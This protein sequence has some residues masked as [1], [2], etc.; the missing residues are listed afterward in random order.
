M[1]EQALT[2]SNREIVHAVTPKKINRIPLRKL[3]E[4]EERGG[5]KFSPEAKKIRRALQSVN[6]PSYCLKEGVGSLKCVDETLRHQ[7]RNRL[8]W[9]LDELIRQ[10]NWA[11]ACGVLSVLLQGTIRDKSLTRNRAKYSVA[12]ELLNNIKGG[13]MSP[14]DIQDVYDLWIA[15]LG[16]L[17]NWST[18]DRFAVRLEHILTFLQNGILDEARKA[19]HTLKQVRDVNI[20]PVANLVFG[21]GFCQQWY[22]GLREE[23]QLTELD[24]SGTNMPSVVPADGIHQPVDYSNEENDANSTVQCDSSTSVANDKVFEDDSNRQIALM[25]IDSITKNETSPTSSRPPEVEMELAEPGGNSNCYSP[26]YCGDLPRLS[27]FYAQGLPTWLFPMKLPTSHE[28]LEDEMKK[29]RRLLNDDHKNALQHLRVA[30]NSIPPVVEAVHPLIQMLL[31]GD[32]VH[33]AFDEVEALLDT[34]IPDRLLTLRLKAGLLEHFDSGNYIKLC[35]CYEEILKKDPTCSDALAKLVL[36]HQL[37]E[38][39]TQ[40]M[41]EMVALHLDASYATCDTWQE[42]A[43]CFLKLSQCEGDRES[44]CGDAD[45]YSQGYLDH[46]NKI[47]ELLVNG[48]SGKAWKLRSRWWL[49]RHFHKSILMSDAASGDLKLL[50]YK[51][52]AA[53]HIYGRH[54][55]YVVKATECIE[56]KNDMELYSLLQTHIL[57][58]VGFCSVKRNIC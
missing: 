37:G 8:T 45:Q 7:H 48:E 10:H 5:G 17:R 2:E 28:K 26:A 11:E 30:I 6:A 52:A 4:F 19:A 16:S 58:S 27:I 43:S 22:S 24:L 31:L 25:E 29:H 55:D 51:A 32:H 34:D 35:I 39:D 53:S 38:Y 18:K 57:N 1:D 47:P 42:L 20:D 49:N 14:K 50:T 46:A 36:M 13:T 40:D 23:F 3:G 15:K 44:N 12:L 21:L 33:E 56:Q 9:L 54:F 41:V